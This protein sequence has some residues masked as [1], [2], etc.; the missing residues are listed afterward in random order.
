MTTTSD[1]N[2]PSCGE[3]FASSQ[4][5]AF[6]W[7]AR[8]DKGLVQPTQRMRRATSCWRCASDVAPNQVACVCGW[9]RPDLAAIVASA[10]TDTNT[11][12]EGN[13]NQ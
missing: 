10:T 11:N 5:V 8:H 4:E 6:H 12:T 7:T 3:A 1:H 2:C 9:V 13:T